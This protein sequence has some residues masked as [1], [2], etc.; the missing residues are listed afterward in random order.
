PHSDGERVCPCH[1]DSSAWPWIDDRHFRSMP[2]SYPLAMSQRCSSHLLI[3]TISAFARL[4]CSHTLSTF[5]LISPGQCCVTRSI[6]AQVWQ[7]GLRHQS[8]SPGES[9]TVRHGPR[10]FFLITDWQ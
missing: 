8:H 5:I 1:G 4:N 10:I 6:S 2:R 3:A 9:T 7:I